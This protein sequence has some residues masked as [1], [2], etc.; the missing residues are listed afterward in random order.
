MFQVKLLIY[1]NIA[2]T[3]INTTNKIPNVIVTLKDVSCILSSF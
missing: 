3:S 1:K 2:I